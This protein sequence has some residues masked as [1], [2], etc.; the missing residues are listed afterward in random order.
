MSDKRAK[1]V[2]KRKAKL[3]KRL[4]VLNSPIKP[5]ACGS[6]FE[7]C[8]HFVVDDLPGYDGVKPA[9]TPCKWLTDNEQARCGT[10]TDR[11]PV[12]GDYRC[13][14]LHDGDQRGRLFFAEDRPDKLGIIFDLTEANH[15]AT[16][17]LKRPVMIARP[18]RAGAF[19]SDAAKALFRRFMER[20][21]VL[22]LLRTP[23][24][25]EFISA[26][27]RDAQKVA[28]VYDKLPTFEVV[29]NT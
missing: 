28:E 14:W 24:E 17:A 5:R 20:G 4:T 2:Q 29:Q 19:D 11:P 16:K 26:D 13:L 7:C 27:I 1:K 15:P 22:V 6:C 9:G 18:A 21:H 10:Y 8:V 3:K 12:C 23:T 25:Y